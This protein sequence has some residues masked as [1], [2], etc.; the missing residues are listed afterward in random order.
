MMTE[1]AQIVSSVWHIL[2]FDTQQDDAFYKD[3]Q[4]TIYKKSHEKHPMVLWACQSIGRNFIFSFCEL[5]SKKFV[6][7]LIFKLEHYNY[8]CDVGIALQEE[9]QERIKNMMNLPAKQRKKWKTEH[10]SIPVLQ[11]CRAQPPPLEL[12]TA[13]NLWT[14]P[15]KCMPEYLHND[16]NGKPFSAMK[17]YRI[18]YAGNKVDIAKLKWEPY[19]KTPKFVDHYRKYIGTRLDIQVGIQNDLKKKETELQRGRENRAKKGLLK[20]ERELDNLGEKKVDNK[21]RMKI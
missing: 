5:F 13:G 14:D 3:V 9:K 1:Y 11:L 10:K 7:K 6:F 18:F 20:R 12:F 21:K 2:Y 16:A 8:I 17:S 19:A 4:Q 15:P